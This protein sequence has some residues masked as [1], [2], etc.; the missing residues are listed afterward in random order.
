VDF[1][2]LTEMQRRFDAERQTTF[3]WSAPITAANSQPLTH[4]TLSLAGEV[5]EV[6]NLVKQYDRGDFTFDELMR[7]LPEELADVMIYVI[8]IGYQAGIDIE[9]AVVDKISRN[10]ERF[11]KANASTSAIER[12][13]ESS[14]E[15]SGRQTGSAATLEHAFLMALYNYAGVKAPADET[16]MMTGALLAVQVA[17]L[18]ETEGSSTMREAA[19]EDIAPHARAV[20]LSYDEL[21]RLGRYDQELLR[22]INA[23]STS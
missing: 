12:R 20:H 10:S 21:A 11:P 15:T 7:K 8:K 23:S 13:S 9:A 2:D 6:A 1:K 3:E 4:N 14:G 19:W 22:L 16:S 17:K 5:G 18:A